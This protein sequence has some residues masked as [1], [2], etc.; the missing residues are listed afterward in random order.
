MLTYAGGGRG[1]GERAKKGKRPKAWGA[2]AGALRMRPLQRTQ[3]EEAFASALPPEA[4]S[5]SGGGGGGDGGAAA[6][7]KKEEEEEEEIDMGGGD[8]FGG[9]DGDD[10]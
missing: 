2:E 6:E 9:G 5:N 1:G 4:A 8:M 7:E 3:R 10:Y